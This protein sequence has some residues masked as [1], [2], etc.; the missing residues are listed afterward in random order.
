[1]EAS[2]VE[3]ATALVFVN[4]QTADCVMSKYPAEWRQKVHVVP[5]GF[6][7]E[8]AADADQPAGPASDNRLHLVYTGRFYDNVRT[9]DAL[10]HALSTLATRRPL[11]NEIAVTFVGS[12]GASHRRLTSRLG[13]DAIVGFTGRVP[14]AESARSAASADV[15]LLIDAPA[16]ENLFLPSKL[17]DYLPARKPILALTPPCGASADLV[18]ALGYPVVAP[19]DESGIVAALEALLAAKREGRL[20]RSAAHDEA[21]KRYDIRRTAGEFA[22]ILVQCA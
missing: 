5:H 20:A 4:R 12:V 3:A 15:L 17:I 2:V 7:A 10:L 19:D 21:A 13:L 8:I 6:D 1:L 9:P 16:D 11:A 18:R 14:F 22:E